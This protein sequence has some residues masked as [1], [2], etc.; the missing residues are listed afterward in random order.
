MTTTTVSGV[1]TEDS[2]L[3]SAAEALLSRFLPEEGGE[4]ASKKKPSEETE[5]TVEHEEGSEEQEASDESPEAE[6]EEEQSEETDDEPKKAYADDE[7]FV[8]VKVG[9]EELEVPVKDLKRLHGQEAALTRKS[10]E[11]AAERKK[12]DA[13][14]QKYA[15]G[16]DALMQRAVAKANEFR[17]VNFLALTKDP[18][19]TAE[20]I[21]VL[22]DEARKAFEEETFLQRELGNFVTAAQQQ[23]TQQLAVR[24][25]ETVKTLSDE[26]SPLYI[27]GWN[28]KTYNDLLTFAKAQGLDADIANNLVDAPA[29]KLLHMAMMYQKGA[30]KVVT[31]K[32]TNKTPKKIVKTSNSPAQPDQNATTAK[33]QQKAMKALRNKGSIENAADAFLAGWETTETE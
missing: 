16:L 31:T 21:S 14:A 19:V 9:D 3:D 24:A 20:Q 5:K 18:N 13:E 32:K 1:A 6:A 22:Q 25:Q 23:Q 11:V 29:L 10:Q 12:V 15:A 7:V 4:D 30:S 2:G 28:Q 33:K 8:K 27:E 26:S 17:K